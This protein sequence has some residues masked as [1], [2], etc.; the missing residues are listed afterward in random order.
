MFVHDQIP[1]LLPGF[2]GLFQDQP[3]P[4]EA[5]GSLSLQFVLLDLEFVV[6]VRKIKSRSEN[7]D[8]CVH[9]F[10]F[11]GESLGGVGNNGHVS[12]GIEW[13]TRDQKPVAFREEYEPVRDG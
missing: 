13:Q 4:A 10:S 2:I 8:V 1:S 3:E 6:E 9:T 7:T 11:S 12:K 5:L